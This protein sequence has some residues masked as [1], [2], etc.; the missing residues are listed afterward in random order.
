MRLIKLFKQLLK[1]VLVLMWLWD[2][3]IIPNK[4]FL[5]QLLSIKMDNTYC[6]ITN[7]FAPTIVFL[8]KSAILRQVAKPVF[9]RKMVLPLA[10]SFVKIYGANLLQKKQKLPVLNYYLVL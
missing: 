8:T 9:S 5:M 7:N 2:I 3:Q 1:P 10:S 6:V 4:A